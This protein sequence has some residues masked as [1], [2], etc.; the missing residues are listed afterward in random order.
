MT[1]VLSQSLRADD[2]TWRR[3]NREALDWQPPIPEFVVNLPLG[4]ALP[5]PRCPRNRS[6]ST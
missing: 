6:R 4:Y 5:S 3:L 1:H 2:D